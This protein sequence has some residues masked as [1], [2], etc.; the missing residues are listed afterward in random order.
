MPLRF[1]AFRT[2][3]II[4]ALYHFFP[5]SLFFPQRNKNGRAYKKLMEVFQA[6][7]LGAI[8]TWGNFAEGKREGES[9]YDQGVLRQG[10]VAEW[11]GECRYNNTALHLNKKGEGCSESFNIENKIFLDSF[12]VGVVIHLRK[13]H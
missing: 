3:N 4:A 9:G 7:F 10:S 5:L 6:N 12:L 11:K 1:V 2:P 8:E 13:L